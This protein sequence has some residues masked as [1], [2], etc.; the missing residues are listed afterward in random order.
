MNWSVAMRNIT[1]GALAGAVLG[2]LVGLLLVWLTDWDNPFWAM[3]AGLGAGA[4]FANTAPMVKR[5]L[6]GDG[7]G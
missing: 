3:S 6:D 4:I 2:L 5:D 7:R 1:V